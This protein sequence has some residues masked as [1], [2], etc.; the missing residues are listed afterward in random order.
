MG[1]AARMRSG[2]ETRPIV[3]SGKKNAF[4]KS[5]YRVFVISSSHLLHA[6]TN[7]DSLE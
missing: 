5:R 1:A 7:S 6:Y 2:L 3:F 4:A